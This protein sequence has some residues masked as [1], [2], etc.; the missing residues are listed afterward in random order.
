MP[1]PGRDRPDR[2]VSMLVGHVIFG[3]VLGSLAARRS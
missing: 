3:A 1:P 2:Q